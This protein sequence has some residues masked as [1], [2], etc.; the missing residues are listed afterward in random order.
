MNGVV[1]SLKRRWQSR[2]LA[3]ISGTSF[4]EDSWRRLRTTAHKKVTEILKQNLERRLQQ[5]TLF[6][7]ERKS[8]SERLKD[9]RFISHYSNIATRTDDARYWTRLRTTCRYR[10]D[11]SSA[12]DWSKTARTCSRVSARTSDATAADGYRG[13]YHRF[14]LQAFGNVRVFFMTTKISPLLLFSLCTLGGNFRKYEISYLLYICTHD[15]NF[16]IMQDYELFNLCI[17]WEVR[18]WEYLSPKMPI[19]VLRS[20]ASLHW[21]PLIM[22]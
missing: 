22:Q 6:L 9:V 14:P 12:V 1:T 17:L 15:G 21:S 18:V 7:R 20:E 3:G 4:N 2:L 11:F 8:F 13:W 16:H 19:K 10:G 5:F